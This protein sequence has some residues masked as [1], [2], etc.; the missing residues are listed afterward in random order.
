M[1]LSG[2]VSNRTRLSPR[3]T[4]L[5]A[6][7]LSLSEKDNKYRKIVNFCKHSGCFV[8]GDISLCLFV[9][10]SFCVSVC[11][12]EPCLCYDK[13]WR[14]PL[15]F[16]WTITSSQRCLFVG[17]RSLQNKTRWRRRLGTTNA[18]ILSVFKMSCFLSPALLYS[19]RTFENHIHNLIKPQSWKSPSKFMFCPLLP[20]CLGW[21]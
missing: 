10:M 15:G 4:H 7:E 9:C 5:S 11:K 14:L 20:S 12:K 2:G 21:V 6:P 3:R 16:I 18:S 8:P 19:K 17:E 13:W 1:A